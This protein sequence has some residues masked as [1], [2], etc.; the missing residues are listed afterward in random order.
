LE[1]V[2]RPVLFK[3]AI[4]ESL[5]VGDFTYVE[6]GPDN[7]L[8]RL[9]EL[10]FKGLNVSRSIDHGSSSKKLNS[11]DRTALP[12]SILC[13]NH[14][15]LQNI[16]RDELTGMSTYSGYIHNGI[17]RDFVEQYVLFDKVSV[18]RCTWV[19][20]LVSVGT[21]W[22]S[23]KK[24]ESFVSL[25][26]LEV[27][28]TL[29][30][31]DSEGPLAVRYSVTNDGRVEVQSGKKGQEIPDRNATAIFRSHP[32]SLGIKLFN[33]YSES[34]QHAQAD[35][36]IEY[37]GTTLYKLRESQGLKCGE[38]FRLLGSG[39]WNAN[40][41]KIVSEFIRPSEHLRSGYLIP[42]TLIEALF[43]TSLSVNDSTHVSKLLS[44]SGIDKVHIRQSSDFKDLWSFPTCV[45][46]VS[47]IS[48]SNRVIL[49][50]CALY[51]LSGHCV[52]V[53]EGVCLERL[54]PL[55]YGSDNDAGY[56]RLE[57][58]W[59]DQILS[60]SSK[61]DASVIDSVLL[62]C[63]EEQ[64]VQ[65]SEVFGTLCDSSRVKTITPRD[66]LAA[67][68][69]DSDAFLSSEYSIVILWN[70]CICH[71]DVTS[72]LSTGSVNM[73]LN[74]REFLELVAIIG[75]ITS[76]VVFV[77]EL[78]AA[79]EVDGD[80]GRAALIGIV[81]SAQLEY[82]HIQ[83]LI[84]NIRSDAEYSWSR[85][86]TEE[87][88]LEIAC[89]TSELEVWNDAG[90]RRV[91]RYCISNATESALAHDPSPHLGA[92]II[93]GGLGGL[94]LLT[95]KVLVEVGVKCLV[96][97]SRSGKVSYE[98][99]GLEEQ[100]RWLVDESGADVRVMRCDV[101]DE[102]SVVSMLECVRSLEG[103]EGGIEGIVHSAG[104]LRDAVIVGG[105][106]AKGCQAVW[107][108]KAYSAY[109]LYLNTLSDHLRLF[110]CFSSIAAS[111]GNVGQSAYGG[112]NGYLEGLMALCRQKGGNAVALEW[113]A[114]AGVGMA[115]AV[116][117]DL[118]RQISMSTA[119]CRVVLHGIFQTNDCI[120]S[121]RIALLPRSLLQDPLFSTSRVFTQFAECEPKRMLKGR[122]G[123]NHDA[124]SFGDG[125]S[126]QISEYDIRDL[127]LK[128]AMS[129][130]GSSSLSDMVVLWV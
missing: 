1:H 86:T 10:I 51:S 6:M 13:R 56:L 115:A 48:H 81:R 108:A 62:V 97:L 83:M 52:M 129:L 89:P 117:G 45:G 20:A 3:K 124:K 34:L 127:V 8:S 119:E 7:T 79:E 43:L 63:R 111:I 87:L 23:S 103:W 65:L 72:T 11:P 18:P 58:R 5:G 9:S 27:F 76:K 69:S 112:A 123:E 100:L 85:A 78:S 113:P 110:L 17:F 99:Q 37:E 36:T 77:S 12:L 105:G 26:N 14:R 118:D 73:C 44:L 32:Y 102:S 57:S 22:I 125:N 98:G 74:A 33:H 55:E 53:C 19:D 80:A 109:L 39:K 38:S 91:R 116:F 64:C 88:I 126:S 28:A 107:E 66:I 84:Y 75:Q 104:V 96:L 106:A 60:N 40:R 29:L 122:S 30:V 54:P 70:A 49:F 24:V 41:T 47:I 71:F 114:I 94:G 46:Y 31:D 120:T 90:T 59:V 95:A 67:K 2:T 4:E 35:C 25:E 42:P 16:H 61:S 93:T 68:G 50:D 15:M 82:P 92:Y 130:T 101:S 128:T 21:D 121:N